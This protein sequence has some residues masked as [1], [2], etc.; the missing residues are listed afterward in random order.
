MNQEE[1]T[2]RCYIQGNWSA[3]EMSDSLLSIRDLYQLRLGLQIIYED[4]RDLDE[5][6]FELRHFPPFHKRIERKEISP[7]LL[8]ALFSGYFFRPYNYNQISDLSK[9]VYPNE[10]LRIRRIEYASPGLKDLV[11]FG[12]IV[13]HIK[14]FTVFLIEHFSNKK[15]RNLDLKEQELDIEA[16]RIENA[17]NFVSLAKECGFEQTELRKLVNLV[18]EKQQPM[19]EIISKDKLTKAVIVEEEDLNKE[20]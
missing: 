19:I 12:E 5:L 10:E 2:L 13:G 16:K 1:K 14:D 3:K 4:Y 15:K 11:G 20:G 17:R 8:Q 7:F 18:D 9:L 6:F